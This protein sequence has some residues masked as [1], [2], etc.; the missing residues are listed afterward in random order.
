LH[1]RWHVRVTA[2][3]N[4]IRIPYEEYAKDDAQQKRRE[5]FVGEQSRKYTEHA[6]IIPKSLQMVYG[7]GMKKP[8]IAHVVLPDIRSVYN[9]GSIFRT[10]DAVGVSKIFLTGHTPTPLDRF[11]RVRKDLAKVALGA[12]QTVAWEYVKSVTALLKRLKKEGVQIVGIEQSPRSV[13]Y[14]KVRIDRRKGASVAFVYG[15]EVGGIPSAVLKLCDIVADIPMRGTKES[16]NVSV[17]AGITL[18]QILG[19]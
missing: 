10:A 1:S 18:F 3:E 14:K 6:K 13:S 16:L 9:V 12:E 19:R 2:F 7:D 17:A 15:N 4:F 11:G 5:H 8:A